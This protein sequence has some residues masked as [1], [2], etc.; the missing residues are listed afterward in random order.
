MNDLSTV[1]YNADNYDDSTLIDKDDVSKIQRMIKYTK[2]NSCNSVTYKKKEYGIGRFYPDGETK[3][4]YGYQNIKTA[5]RRLVIDGKLKSLD[6]VFAHVNILNQLC[7][8]YNVYHD[9]VKHYSDKGN[10]DVV[11]GSIMSEYSVDRGIAQKLMLII[12]FGGSF[13]TWAAELKINKNVISLQVVSDYDDEIQLIMNH[14]AIKHF[15]GYTTAVKKAMEVKIKKRKDAFR[16][17]LVLYLQDI[18]SQFIMCLYDSICK[19]EI[20]VHSLIHD[21]LHIDNCE[22]DMDELISEIKTKTSFDVLLESK[23]VTPSES[24][25]KWFDA[26]KPF[27]KTSA[28]KEQRPDDM[29]RI[30]YHTAKWYAVSHWVF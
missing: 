24:D 11:L 26:H 29:R 22:I 16:S 18:E 20:K 19:K 6:L 30:F 12:T 25:L 10:R 14:F 27:F 17:A 4:I 7:D 3:S 8:K 28:E 9:S 1:K 15:P 23:P 5:I 2:R 13:E 21:E